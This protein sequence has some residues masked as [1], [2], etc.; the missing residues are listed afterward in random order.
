MSQVPHL[1]NPVFGSSQSTRGAAGGPTC[2]GSQRESPTVALQPALQVPHWGHQ[3]TVSEGA[4][5]PQFLLDDVGGLHEPE[6]HP[7]AAAKGLLVEQ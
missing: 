3:V 6:G 7:A 5:V 2:G 4:Q 1:K